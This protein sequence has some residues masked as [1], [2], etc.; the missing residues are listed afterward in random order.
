MKTSEYNQ[1][2]TEVSD[3][4]YRYA[5]RLLND[6]FGAEDAVQ[7]VF[8]RIWKKRKEVRFEEARNY[9]FK[10]TY[11]LCMDLIR[12]QKTARKYSETL[13]VETRQPSVNHQFELQDLLHQALN[14]IS[15]MHRSLILLRDYEGYS[16]QEI[17]EITGLSESQVKVYIFRGR[18]ALK[19]IISKVNQYE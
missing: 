3:D 7:E 11:N 2:V 12:K 10:S 1:C 9:L 6:Q 14:K 4:L 8:E 16:Y 19:S 13:P 5:Y 18:K 15:D 17:G